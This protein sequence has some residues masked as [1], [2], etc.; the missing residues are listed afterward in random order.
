MDKELPCP[1]FSVYYR[2]RPSAKP[3]DS[4]LS[5]SKIPSFTHSFPPSTS[6]EEFCE[7]LASTFLPAFLSGSPVHFFTYGFPAT[8]GSY[9]F[10]GERDSPGLVQ[11]FARRLLGESEVDGLEVTYAMYEV[12]NGEV[13]DLV[14]GDRK[15]KKVGVFGK[16]IIVKDL[17]YTD[18][19]EIFE[20]NSLLD[21]P[22][23]GPLFFEDFLKNRIWYP[24]AKMN[25]KCDLSTLVHSITNTKPDGTS[26]ECKFFVI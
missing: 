11:V 18:L 3:E 14:K 17:E 1:N 20:E 22:Y 2:P 15:V 16:D 7:H 4:D 25:A 21:E 24:S 8:G 5:T 9:S 26:T 6:Q 12:Y 19:R 23:S 10:E 13:Y